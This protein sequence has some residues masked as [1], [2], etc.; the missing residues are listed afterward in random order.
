LSSL[1]NL[2]Y[3]LEPDMC[4]TPDRV[5]GYDARPFRLMLQSDKT[6]QWSK[7]AEHGSLIVM[8]ASFNDTHF[9]AV[10]PEKYPCGV[11]IS[12]VG[13]IL[14][15]PRVWCCRKGHPHPKYVQYV[16]CGPSKWGGGCQCHR[17]VLQTGT[18]YG[19]D[20]DPFHGHNNWISK[21][22]AGFRAYA[23]GRMQEPAF[24]KQAIKDL[25]GK[26]LLCWCIQDGSE[27]APFCVAGNREQTVSIAGRRYRAR[28]LQGKLTAAEWQELKD[29][30]VSVLDGIKYPKTQ[31]E[32]EQRLVRFCGWGWRKI[33]G[34]R[35]FVGDALE[36]LRDEGRITS[37]DWEPGKPDNHVETYWRV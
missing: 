7:P 9:H 33:D 34:P 16:G 26:H 6:K 3:L 23:E 32:I 19:N 8:P 28:S 25:R 37:D 17:D 2:D 31:S 10:L 14:T 22:E 11:R 35:N 21:D 4:K 20:Q 12:I 13:K 27:R 15:P 24:R 18:I 30:I 29:D 5:A 1:Y 36:W